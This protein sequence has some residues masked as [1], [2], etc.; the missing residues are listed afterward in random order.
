M[1]ATNKCLAQGNKSGTRGEA[2]KK[3][4]AAHR[5]TAASSGRSSAG[6]TDG[7]DDRARHDRMVQCGAD[8]LAATAD[9]MGRAQD[10][11]PDRGHRGQRLSDARTQLGTCRTPSLRVL[12]STAAPG[13]ARPPWLSG[14]LARA[15]GQTPHGPAAQR[16]REARGRV[17]RRR[18]RPADHQDAR[19]PVEAADRRPRRAAVRLVQLEETDVF[20]SQPVAGGV[21]PPI[22]QA[23]S[24]LPQPWSQRAMLTSNDY[25]E[26]AARC[27]E[28]AS[29]S[30]EPTVAEALRALASDY[31]ARAAKLH[32]VF[33][34]PRH[35]AARPSIVGA[36]KPIKS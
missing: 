10:R 20:V 21:V 9:A 14:D 3:R 29:E 23:L 11:A 27:T 26:L 8:G 5:S 16:E 24:M 6:S 36:D 35:E 7:T 2:T 12:S 1:A 32:F 34:E 19:P 15:A 31:L 28:L 22:K 18:R 4:D 25:K 13:R 17:Q 30:S 33:L